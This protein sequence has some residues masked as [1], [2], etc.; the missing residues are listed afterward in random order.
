MSAPKG[1]K[2]ALGNSGKPKIWESVDDLQ[3]D[4]DAY[5]QWI[6]DNPQKIVYPSKI[7][8]ET[9]KPLVYEVERYPTI[10]GL[11]L[12]LDCSVHTLR[13]YQKTEGYEEYFTAIERAKLKIQQAKVE[14]GASGIGN[15]NFIMFDLKNNH[16]YTDKSEQD[17]NVKTTEYIIEPP[18]PTNV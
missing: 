11:A 12:F 5:F 17:V 14:R 18:K 16:G 3:K 4:I 1:N 7:D 8:E 2:F 6:K 10:E 9:K 15:P 13:N